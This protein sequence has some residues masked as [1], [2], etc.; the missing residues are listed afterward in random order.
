MW[1][2]E[3][4]DLENGA[5]RKCFG[6]SYFVTALAPLTYPTLNPLCE[7][8]SPGR[9][10]KRNSDLSCQCGEAIGLGRCDFEVSLCKKYF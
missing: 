5:A 10:C 4:N 8:C 6:P 7:G 3:K 9:K 1:A 2:A